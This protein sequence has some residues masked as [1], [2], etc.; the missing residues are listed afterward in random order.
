M[1][2][3]FS[4]KI[5]QI[6]P[7]LVMDILRKAKSLERDGRKVIHL[8]LGEP[9]FPTPRVIVESAK[10][11]LENGETRYTNSLGISELRNAISDHYN[12]SYNLSISP[13]RVIV[14]N[15]TSPAMLILFQLLLEENDEVIISDPHYACYPSF[16]SSTGAKSILVPCKNFSSEIGKYISDKTKIILINSPSNPTGIRLTREELRQISNTKPII[17]SDEIYHG[18]STGNRDYS[19]L[20]FSDNSIVINGFSKFFAMT[21]WR[22]GYMIVPE[23]YIR[24]LEILQQNFFISANPFVQIAGITALQE[25]IPEARL[26]NE[27][28]TE[29]RKLALE[30][31]KSIGLET[32]PQ[33]DGAFYALF[34][35]SEYEK[36]S[37]KLASEILA[38]TGVAL[39]PG[40][41]FGPFGE[42]HLR[43]SYCNSNENIERGIKLIGEYLKEK[44]L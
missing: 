25:A 1:K 24:R 17:V 37:M 8:E 15:G 22:L 6:E 4:K 21:G 16:I 12:H 14:T 32:N 18:I 19:A 9:D 26:M 3:K 13:N 35:V 7:F 20:E 42:G 41:D 44:Y 33:P 5:D 34:N 23:K 10:K 11:A 38:M 28:Y 31:L 43:L 39:A 30:G 36:D 29:R 2:T 27:I 40:K